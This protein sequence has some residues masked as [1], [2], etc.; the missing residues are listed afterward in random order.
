MKKLLFA[1]LLFL[2]FFSF[3]QV[4]GVFTGSPSTTGSATF[5]MMRATHTI[6]AGWGALIG[7]P[8]TTV[9][10]A[11]VNGITISTVQASNWQAY[12]LGGG[13]FIGSSDSI[14]MLGSI[15]SYAPDS[16]LRRGFFTYSSSGNYLADSAQQTMSN[17][18]YRIT[19]LTVGHPYTINI[20]SAMTT[21]Y[22]FEV[23][24]NVHVLGAS[25]YITSNLNLK[26]N[27]GT[28]I[29]LTNVYPD[30]LGGVNL[31]FFT[32]EHISGQNLNICNVVNIVPS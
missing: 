2:P 1:L 32:Q 8:S 22:G 20:G 24:V 30:A 6:P 13:V 21:A 26:G 16:N 17:A 11:T 19:G 9:L 31:Y 5:A 14:G 15:L 23:T 29:S 27:T 4:A 25:T 10:T 3:S 7:D 12:P 28:P 18:N